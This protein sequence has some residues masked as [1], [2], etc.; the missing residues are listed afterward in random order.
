MYRWF[1]Q[2]ANHYVGDCGPV[3]IVANL[4]FITALPTEVMQQ[5]V[6]RQCANIYVP[7]VVN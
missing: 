3:L 1:T 5:I 7:F 4:S 2:N 6:K